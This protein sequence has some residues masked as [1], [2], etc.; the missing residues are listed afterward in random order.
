M[1]ITALR[2]STRLNNPPLYTKICSKGFSLNIQNVQNVLETLFLGFVNVK[3]TFRLANIVT[4]NVTF[5]CSRN[6]F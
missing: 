4:F 2:N 3:G 1:L 5:E 6:I